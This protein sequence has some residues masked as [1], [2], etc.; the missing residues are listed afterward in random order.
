MISSLIPAES[1]Q[2]SDPAHRDADECMAF[3]VILA[4]DFCNILIEC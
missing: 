3:A 2:I 1:H 4:D